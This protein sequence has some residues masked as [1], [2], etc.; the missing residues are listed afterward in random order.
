MNLSEL[1]EYVEHFRSRVLADALQEATSAYWL[2]RARVFAEVGT[3]GCDEIA[4]ACR[5]RAALS[6]AG[7]GIPDA[8]ICHV[9]DTLTS[10]WTCSCGITRLDVGGFRRQEVDSWRMISN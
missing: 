10:P 2:R 9:C 4:Q 1:P 7:D 3:E 5:N 6:L 8:V